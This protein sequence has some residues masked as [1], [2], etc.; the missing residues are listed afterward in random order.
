MQISLRNRL[1][2]KLLVCDRLLLLLE[3]EQLTLP[4]LVVIE[5]SVDDVCDTI[6]LGSQTGRVRVDGW[7]EL[8][9]N[10]LLLGR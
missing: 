9:L 4:I 1:E 5:Q 8:Q 2:R 7:L 10:F 6:L 3:L